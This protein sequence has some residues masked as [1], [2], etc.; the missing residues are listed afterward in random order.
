[1]VMN[2]NRN[3]RLNKRLLWLVASPIEP[4]E[5]TLTFAHQGKKID[6]E[7]RHDTTPLSRRWLLL[8]RRAFSKVIKLMVERGKPL[9]SNVNFAPLLGALKSH[10]L[11]LL[12]ITVVVTGLSLPVI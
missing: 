3:L 5:V 4:I 11:K 6:K 8:L 10:G 1:M 12:L 2:M 7:S 9:E